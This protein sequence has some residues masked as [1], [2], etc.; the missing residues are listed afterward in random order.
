MHFPSSG[1]RRRVCRFRISDQSRPDRPKTAEFLAGAPT[2][3]PL[4]G[5]VMHIQILAGEESTSLPLDATGPLRPRR[6]YGVA[7]IS[8]PVVGV[9]DNSTVRTRGGLIW[10]AILGL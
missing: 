7:E 9:A 2:M 5:S 1:Q 8:Q 4:T 6:S 10:A 3:L